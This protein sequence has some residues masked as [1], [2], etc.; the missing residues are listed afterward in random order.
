MLHV[1]LGVVVGSCSTSALGYVCTVQWVID[2]LL[3]KWLRSVLGW[4]AYVLVLEVNHVHDTSLE[5]SHSA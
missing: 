1:V 3:W 2:M 5:Q 4:P